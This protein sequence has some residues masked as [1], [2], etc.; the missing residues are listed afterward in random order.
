[1]TEEIALSS[2]LGAPVYD[3]SGTLAGHVREVAIS[4]QDDPTRVSDL[5]VKTSGGDRLLPAKAVR[6]LERSAVRATSVRASGKADEWPPLVSSE[7]MLLLERDLLDQ[8]I[9]DVSG[10]KVVRVNDVDLRPEPVN[11]SVKLRVGRV[12]IGLRGAVRRLLRGLA[13]SRAIEA[14]ASRMPERAIPWEAV[15]LIETDPARRV[16][17][18]LEYERL[19]KLHPADIAD[20]LEDLAPAEREAVFESLDEEVAAD[21]LEEIDPKM[22]VELMRSI[23]SDKA[24]DIV[25]EMEPD[26]A[27]DLLADLP[28]ET[29]EEIMEE[30]EPAEREEVAE[31]LTF[32][33]N[34][35]A[36]RMTT[37]YV[38][39]PP[40]ATVA[41][42]ILKLRAF[43][44]ETDLI[45][46]IFLVNPGGKLAGAVPL[47]SLVLAGQD[48]RLS[49]LAPEHVISCKV[50]ANDKDVA[51]MFDK[52][53]LMSLPVV[54]E[55]GCLSGVVTADD[56]I[57]VLRDRI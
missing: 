22:Q 15:D 42:A 38:A 17:L 4:P 50:D 52:Y 28:E 1:M 29:S 39:V 34:T 19:S 25:E 26:A 30:M 11:G 51:E 21:A 8:Q 33:E 13:P 31:L 48:T 18:K 20:I 5:V 44:G 53:N 45:N 37:E 55:E 10:R 24:A 57:S 35:A 12:D 56:V 2:I 36:G 6:T 7:G 43:A 3:G 49:T 46:T 32:K 54:D 23:D 9:I 14:L 16:H 47:V 27:A 41:D 40:G